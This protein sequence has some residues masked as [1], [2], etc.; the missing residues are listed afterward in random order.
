MPCNKNITIFCQEATFFCIQLKIKLCQYLHRPH[1]W[2]LV[3]CEN[4]RNKKRE[5]LLN[6][7]TG[8][9]GNEAQCATTKI[10]T[11]QLTNHG[12]NYFYTTSNMHAD[13][14]PDPRCKLE[15]A[16]KTLSSF[17]RAKPTLPLQHEDST[18]ICAKDPKYAVSLPS[19]HCAFAQSCWEGDTDEH[20]LSHIKG[21]HVDLVAEVAL[22]LRKA[23]GL[24]DEDQDAAIMAV[25]NEAVAIVIR[26]GAPLANCSIDRRCLR[27]YVTAATS[28]DLASLICI[29]CARRFPYVKD[30]K[31]N[32]MT[33]ENLLVE[34]PTVG[35]TEFMFLGLKKDVAYDIFSFDAYLER[36]GQQEGGPNLR[37]ALH[38]F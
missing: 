9:D 21:S 27:K 10:Q 26:E 25:Y 32:Y 20:L 30:R 5:R 36:Y 6:A 15:V 11:D 34:S 31:S 22:L 1:Q 14:S 13:I 18:L 16:L 35:N 33:W 19:K 3:L 28:P 2:E 24:R 12:G 37:S 38:E 23:R 8:C 4:M 17:I 7:C 29:S